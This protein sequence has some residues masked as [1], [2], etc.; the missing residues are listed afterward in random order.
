M[1]RKSP[2]P[3]LSISS[4]TAYLIGGVPRS[5]KSTI[6]Q[7]VIAIHPMFSAS[8]DTIRTLQ[9]GLLAEAD[10]PALFMGEK[11]FS[12]EYIR[13]LCG[14]GKAS[15]IITLQNDESQVV[16]HS[17][18]EFIEANIAEGSD[19]LVEGVAI[20]PALISELNCKFKVVF[21][22]NSSTTH[23]AMLTAARSNPLDWMHEYSD[24]TIRLFSHFTSEYSHWFKA[25]T[26]KYGFEYHEIADSAFETSVIS[27][28]DRLL[29]QS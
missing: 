16:W 2:D 1:Q 5:G 18:K 22:G 8:T 25:E 11:E 29:N 12:P 15:E 9:R 3:R 27:T 19:V 6:A 4:A 17:V 13:R 24:E 10:Y 26:Q 20:L 23:E 7:H 28:A 14:T 21:V